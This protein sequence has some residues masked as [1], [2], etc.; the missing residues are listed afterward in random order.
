DGR[1]RCVL[2]DAAGIAAVQDEGEVDDRLVELVG[3]AEE[4]E[5]GDRASAGRNYRLVVAARIGRVGR[6]PSAVARVGEARHVTRAGSRQHVLDGRDDRVA[7]GRGVGEHVDL[8]EQERALQQV[9]H[10]L[11][12]SDT[13]AEVTDAPSGRKTG[14]CAVVVHSDHYRSL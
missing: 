10:R 8:I 13:G 12:V 1:V 4:V 7:R 5:I 11:H 9:L 14:L 6:E 3:Q 2:V